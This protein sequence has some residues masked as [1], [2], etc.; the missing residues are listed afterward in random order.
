MK[1]RSEYDAIIVGARCAGA[2][3]AM[4]LARS[5][6]RV[7]ML[8]RG[9]YAGDTL[10]THALMRGGVFQ[11]LRWDVLPA[12]VN[13]GTPPVNHAVFHYG[14]DEVVV[15]ISARHGVEALYAPRRTLLDRL[16]VDAARDAGAQ[17][18]YGMRVVDVLY[19]PRRIVSGVV[20]IDQEG[21]SHNIRADLVIGADG[22][23][24]TVARLVDAEPYRVGDHASGVIYAYHRALGIDGYHW[25]YAPGAAAGVIP[26]NDGWT[27]VFASMPAAAFRTAVGGGMDAG[28]RRLLAHVAPPLAASLR[29]GPTDY[30]SFSGQV[31]VMRQSWGAGWALVGD[32]GCYRDPVTAH[33][34]TDALR[35]AEL[36]ANAVLEGSE[37]ALAEYQ[38]ARDAA[39]LGLFAV[40]DRIAS[41][42]WDL[43]E[44]RRLNED[45][46]EEMGAA[47]RNQGVG[48]SARVAE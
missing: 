15:P 39:T 5:G 48:M 2:A 44:I 11:L 3:T 10:S 23:R 19:S 24:S 21:R 14:A 30:H 32:A 7:L 31:G 16:L 37:G 6:R 28:Y 33:G 41:F 42:Q 20:L 34:I 36:L 35:D 29:H 26:T 12:V 25:Y 4:L 40:T 13:A 8:D 17:V 43:A 45:L 1:M 27:C 9:E 18:G 46:A 22:L 38:R 47:S